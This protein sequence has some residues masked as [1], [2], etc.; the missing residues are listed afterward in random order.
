MQEKEGYKT[1]ESI[2]QELGIGQP[3]ARQALRVLNIQPITF[4][5]DKRIKYYRPEDIERIKEWL[6]N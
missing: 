2:M 3:K 1:L 6:S 4:N 5:R